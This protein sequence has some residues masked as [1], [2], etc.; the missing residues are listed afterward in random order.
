[1]RCGALYWGKLTQRAQQLHSSAFIEHDPALELPK[2]QHQSA[3][4]RRRLGFL[5]L[6]ASLRLA[7]WCALA[8]LL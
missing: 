5:L 7:A 2:T 4:L 8:C 1:M 6:L 3:N